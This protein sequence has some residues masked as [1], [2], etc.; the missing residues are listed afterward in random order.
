MTRREPRTAFGKQRSRNAWCLLLVV[1]RARVTFGSRKAHYTSHHSL[2]TDLM[3]VLQAESVRAY[4]KPYIKVVGQ[5]LLRGPR[6]LIAASPKMT[7]FAIH[8]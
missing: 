4:R 2:L 6:G 7:A 5:K 3:L 1:L 8:I